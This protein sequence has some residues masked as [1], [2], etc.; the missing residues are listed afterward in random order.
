VDA[1][2]DFGNNALCRRKAQTM[3]QTGFVYNGKDAVHELM[4]QTES[5]PVN[6]MLP[7]AGIDE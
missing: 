2:A 3:T 7:T 4:G 1:V 6:N 5:D